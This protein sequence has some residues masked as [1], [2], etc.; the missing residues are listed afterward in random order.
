MSFQVVIDEERFMWKD[1][2][3]RYT[4]LLVLNILVTTYNYEKGLHLAS[5]FLFVGE[6]ISGFEEEQKRLLLFA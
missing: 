4:E 1:L 3:V 2:C 6:K 5:T